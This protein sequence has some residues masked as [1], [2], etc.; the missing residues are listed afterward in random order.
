MTPAQGYRTGEFGYW[1][2]QHLATI[3]RYRDYVVYYD[4]GDSQSEPNVA[5]IHGFCGSEVTNVTRLAEV[6]VMIAT[7]DGELVLLIEIEEREISPKKL[8]GDL[9]ALLMCN[10]FAVKT[11]ISHQYFRIAPNTRLVVAGVVP[12]KGSRPR[13]ITEVI[14][15]RLA[16]LDGLSNSISPNNIQFVFEDS[17]ETTVSVLKK[18]THELLHLGT[19]WS[20]L[21]TTGR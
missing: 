11:N 6:D 4:H 9:L 12:C 1:L 14:E 17:I 18:R 5:V 13:K 8:L 19:P 7:P 15:P 20:L 3:P 10:G 2:T 16:E 21:T